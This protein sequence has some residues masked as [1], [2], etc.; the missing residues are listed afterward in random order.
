MI[1]ARDLEQRRESR[2]VSVDGVSD[3]F[4]NLA[5]AMHVSPLPRISITR[6]LRVVNVNVH[7]D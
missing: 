1:F 6:T 3:A 4:R 7:V 2:R 5:H